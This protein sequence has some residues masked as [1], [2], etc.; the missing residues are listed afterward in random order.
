MKMKSSILSFIL[1][2]CFIILTAATTIKADLLTVKPARPASTAVLITTWAG[3]DE[4]KKK[5]LDYAKKGYIVRSTVA[6]N[7]KAIIVLEKYD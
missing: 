1:G 7:T 4:T 6:V 2:C 3:A 5:I